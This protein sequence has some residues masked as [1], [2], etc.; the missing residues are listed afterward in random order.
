VAVDPNATKLRPGAGNG[1]HS[2]Q[3]SAYV[4]RDHSASCASGC[5]CRRLGCGSTDECSKAVALAQRLSL[6]SENA[7]L[8]TCAIYT[9]KLGIFH[10]RN[11]LANRHTVKS[12]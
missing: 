2:S 10:Y 12:G 4:C 6:P 9:L 8:I 7:I 5:G 3:K 11:L 1:S